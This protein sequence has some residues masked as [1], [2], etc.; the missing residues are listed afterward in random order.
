MFHVDVK[1]D[2]IAEI[3]ADPGGFLRGLGLGQD[4]GLDIDSMSLTL[5]RPATA[6][7]DSRGAWVASRPPHN[8]KPDA[9]TW[10]CYTI[11]ESL[12]CH[13]HDVEQ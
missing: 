3:T 6:W 1:V 10:C 2:E 11:G 5:S 12:T 13:R 4:H 8:I 7:S 9:V